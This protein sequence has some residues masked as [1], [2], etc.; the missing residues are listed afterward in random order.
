MGTR[1]SDAKDLGRISMGSPLKGVPNRGGVGSGF[2]FR[3][4]FAK[5]D[6]VENAIIHKRNFQT[7]F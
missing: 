1:F 2:C 7:L 4:V 5:P 3:L 6:L